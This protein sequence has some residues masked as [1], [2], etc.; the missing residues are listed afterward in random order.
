MD[1]GHVFHALYSIALLRGAFQTRLLTTGYLPNGEIPTC[2]IPTDLYQPI[3]RTC[4]WDRLVLT[5]LRLRYQPC[6][7][8]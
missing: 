6:I 4:G 2:L 7:S 8:Q 3:L 5:A 1:E